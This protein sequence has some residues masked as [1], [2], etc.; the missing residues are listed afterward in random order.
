MSRFFHILR[1]RLA[2]VGRLIAEYSRAWV[3]R[4]FHGWR[5]IADLLVISALLIATACLWRAPGPT[6][7]VEEPGL[8]T[9]RAKVLSVDN[10][11]LQV[12]GLVRFGTQRL[13]V[14]LA[15]GREAE[16]YNEL[17]AQLELDKTFEPGDTAIVVVQNRRD[18]EEDEPPVVHARD[19][20]RLGWMGLLFGAFAVLLVA[21]GGFTGLRA[22]FTFFFSCLAI[23]KLMIPYA[24][25]GHSA[26]LASFLTVAA[27]TAAILFL[28]AGVTK[29]GVSAF[30][31]SMLGVV[32]SFALARLTVV[33]L[34]INGATMPFAQ[35]LLYSGVPG[36][37]LQ[38]IFIGAIVLAS[39]GAVMDLAMDIASGA[40]EVRRHNPSL[41]RKELFLSCIRIGRSVV[42]TMTTTLLLAYSGG[43]LT[44]LMV[45]AA[46]GKQPVDFLNTTLVSAEVVKTLV[47]S[48]GLVLVAPFTALVSAFVFKPVKGH[49]L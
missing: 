20:W 39:S 43:F 47:G 11:G 40:E 41:S 27:L 38:D 14:R 3:R 32:A 6:P 31:G 23:W 34:H 10:D 21:F 49:D 22:L 13:T 5:S 44:L 45:F 4:R 17:R 19:H 25:E 35:Q 24:L 9:E 37:D 15:D 29:K 28:V 30:I 2:L 8:K 36:I 12:H 33:A 26:A 7:I 42:G 48:L 1:W 18:D 46:E 16:A